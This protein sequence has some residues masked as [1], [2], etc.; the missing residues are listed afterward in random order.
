M[1]TQSLAETLTVE[2]LFVESVPE[3]TYHVASEE[4][5]ES[6]TQLSDN[7]EI[8]EE[9]PQEETNSNVLPTRRA[10]KRLRESPLSTEDPKEARYLRYIPNARG[11][12]PEDF[13]DYPAYVHALSDPGFDIYQ[14]CTPAELEAIGRSA[15]PASRSGNT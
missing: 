9:V 13:A 10:E 14:G 11:L 2:Q 6:G 3:T 12:R 1:S 4:I 15:N 5:A 8:L 7:G